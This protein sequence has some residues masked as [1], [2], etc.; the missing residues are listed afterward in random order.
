LKGSLRSL[1]NDSVGILSEFTQFES[2]LFSLPSTIT[3]NG[4]EGIHT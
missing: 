2:S 4:P 1:S 3:R